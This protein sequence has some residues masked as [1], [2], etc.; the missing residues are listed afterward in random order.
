MNKAISI[1]LAK[2]DY[3]FGKP[4]M[5]IIAA[6]PMEYYFTKMWIIVHYLDEGNWTKKQYD[7]TQLIAYKNDIIL[8]LPISVLEGVS[9]PAIYEVYLESSNEIDEPLQDKLI[10]S[11]THYLYRQMMDGLMGTDKCT[12]VSDDVVKKYL[13]L[14]GHQQALQAGDI[15]I[16]KEYFKLMYNGFSKCGSVGRS[17]SN[18]GCHDRY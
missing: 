6:N 4:Y 15:E 5:K 13:M 14:Y 1:S 3:D 9:G 17:G 18:C 12:G 16:A 8:N 2:I 7:V 10:L 11:D